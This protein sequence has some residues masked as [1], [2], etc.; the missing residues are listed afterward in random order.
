MGF[1]DRLF[2]RGEDRERRERAPETQPLERAPETRRLDTAPSA[3]EQL[4]DEQ[5]VER[6]R[7]LLRTAPPEAIEQAHEEAFARLTPQQR[8][9]VLQQLS[10]NLPAHERAALERNGDDPRT[11]ARAATRAE[12]REPGTI[13]R[14]FYVPASPG[15]G[16]MGGMGMGGM[17]MGGMGGGMGGMGGGMGGMGGMMGGGMRS[18]PPTS[19]LF[20]TLSP[21]QT[22]HLPTTVVSLTGPD[23]NTRPILPQKGERLQVL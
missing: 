5:A 12:L 18:V 1:L 22:R 8:A 4:T 3:P 6:Y 11:L 20:T 16:G 10:Q 9:M 21:N 14:I 15:Y 7:Y 13:E 17:G 2:G 23:A 19:L